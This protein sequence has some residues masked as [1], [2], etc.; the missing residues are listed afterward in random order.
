MAHTIHSEDQIPTP[1]MARP[2]VGLMAWALFGIGSVS[3]LAYGFA[4]SRGPA[5]R[6]TTP[7]VAIEHTPGSIRTYGSI[8]ALMEG[9]TGA[10]V[11][12]S[13]LPSG[14]GVIG[15]GSLS[16]LRGEIAI[17]R[18]AKWLSYSLPDR[19]VTVENPSSSDQ[20]AAFL[21]LADVARWQAQRFDEAVPFDRLATELERRATQA[22]LDA[23][24]PF[25]LLIE[26]TFSAVELNVVNGGALG[27]EKPTAERLRETAVTSQVP[28]AKGTVVG[29]F[30]ANGG[31]RFVHPGQRLHLHVVLPDAR[32]AGHL[33]SVRIE[34]GSLLRLPTQ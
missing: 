5:L 25:P 15:I 7:S 30:A 33:D 27:A 12:L 23:S 26:G 32:Q 11:S 8:P 21:V 14:P 4:V 2:N 13:V 22:G 29:I 9:D 17:V 3:L 28:R 31:E 18:G 34:A 20:S 10:K 24:R 6:R 16:E 1:P 19:R